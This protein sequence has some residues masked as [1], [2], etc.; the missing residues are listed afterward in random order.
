M[1]GNLKEEFL[2]DRLPQGVI[3]LDEK[4][5]IQAVVGGIQDRIEDLRAYG[6]NMQQFFAVNTFPQTGNNVVLVDLQSDQGKTY[7]RSLDIQ[8]D[9][10]AD[11][12]AALDTWAAAQLGLDKTAILNARY[13]TDLLR[14]V[15]INTL[16][17]LAQTVGAVLYKTSI[18]P[19]D[20]VQAEQKQIIAT[21]FP[22]LQIKGTERSF[23]ALGRILGFDDVRMTPLWSRLSVRQPNDIGAAANDP[24][25]ATEAEYIPQQSFSPFYNPLKTNDGPF[26]TWTGTVNNGTNSTQFYTQAVNDFS[27]FVE[28][29]V[30]AT[31]HGTVVDPAN[32]TYALGSSGT[33]SLGGPHKKAYVDP[34]GA[35]VRFQAIA[36]GEYFNGMVISVGTDS[37]GTN[38][39]LSITDRLSAIKYR[40][41]YFDL[42]VTAYPDKI[43][44]V[45][46]SSAAQRN[47]DLANT[48][49]LTVDGTAV[50][51]YR[52]WIS[53]SMTSDFTVQDW[54]TMVGNTLTV[55]IPRVEA[56][57]VNRQLN[58]TGVTAAATQ[59]TQALEEVRAATRYPRKSLGGLLLQDSAGYAA[60]AA[61]V[62]LS[63]STPPPS[64][65][66]FIFLPQDVIGYFTDAFTY[67]TIINVNGT[68]YAL[69]G[70]MTFSSTDGINWTLIGSTTPT[71]IAFVYGNSLFVAVGGD[72]GI[73]TSS[74]A[75]NWQ[76]QFTADNTLTG[77]CFGGGLYVAVGYFG[78]IL[79]ST[80]G[81]SWSLSV[82]PVG[83]ENAYWYNVAYV[84][85]LYVAVGM[86]TVFG[87]G[88]I[89]TSTNGILWNQK[90]C[91][92]VAILDDVTYGGG[93]F[94]VVGLGGTVL[95]STNGNT[96]NL[97]TSGI[98][99]D[100]RSVI[101]FDGAFYVGNSYFGGSNGTVWQSANGSTWTQ[102]AEAPPPIMQGW[103]VAAL[104]LVAI[105]NSNSIV[106]NTQTYG[107]N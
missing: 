96:W 106:V 58:M 13:G 99:A 95:T 81:T 16:A 9:T 76:L 85:G 74:D 25:F 51:P 36:E 89:M 91:G 79:T 107:G 68:L 39:I 37:T 4:G 49:A 101:Y 61:S 57:A 102:V 56:S 1:I 70:G 48:P 94:I 22:R 31:Q 7:T 64:P 71:L 33:D 93:Q 30:L 65:P 105:S 26:Y 44:E 17:Y 88:A 87:I 6:K 92:T 90:D 20:Q 53:G 27:P 78:T 75:I 21:Y 46:G 12:T 14:L 77:I 72:L 32:G 35:G 73:Y 8:T 38:K 18:I 98:S 83:L 50:S 2:Y 11:G 5:L 23:E 19:D 42:A 60:Y 24:D 15:D 43:E 103:Q 40:S 97:Q 86:D 62:D 100:I 104:L 54:V 84:G 45:F 52:P 47:K 3:D 66:S 29:I 59:V 67:R 55:V 10:P 82:M 69:T 28:T 63:S 34:A 41:S 80:N